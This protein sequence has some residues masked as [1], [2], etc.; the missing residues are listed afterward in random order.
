MPH[1]N[2]LNRPYPYSHL[3][4][5]SD[6]SID[7]FLTVTK[8][9]TLNE[10]LELAGS[11]ATSGVGQLEG[12]N[13]V[14]GLLEVGA[15]SVDLVDQVLNANNTVLAKVVLDQLVV[16]ESDALLVDLAVSTLVDQL[17]DG[18]EVGVAVSDVGVDNGQHFLGSLGQL[19]EGTVVDLE[20][21]EELED[22]ARLGGNLVDTAQLLAFCVIYSR[23]AMLT[24]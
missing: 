4:H 10:V 22:L 15:N 3:V 23:I 19:D 1:D 14:A 9:T 6:E 17:T 13:E 21:P 2:C 16:G 8:V 24:P 20:E 7:V 5:L 12:P 11:E 18:L